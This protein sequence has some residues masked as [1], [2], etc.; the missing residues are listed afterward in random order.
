MLAIRA[1]VQEEIKDEEALKKK[2]T[3]RAQTRFAI[4]LL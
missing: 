1:L 4:K 2:N 3:K